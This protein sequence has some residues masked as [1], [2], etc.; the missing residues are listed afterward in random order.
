MFP[1]IESAKSAKEAVSYCL[2]PP[3]GVRG[4]AHTVVRA[5]R[6][7]ID[8]GYLGNYIDELLIM[9]QVESEE[10]V[11][12][13]DEIA[14]VDGV[15]CIQMGPLDLSASLG[16]LWDPGNKKVRETMWEAEKK[17]LESKKDNV[18]VGAYLSGFAM[19]HDGPQYLKSRGYHMVAGAVDVGLFRSAAVED[20][21]SFKMSL[22]EEGSDNEQGEGKDGDEKYWSE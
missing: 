20:V 10:A 1:M 11:K 17:V 12:H 19:P 16:C 8:E 22:I 21:N 15:D 9:C 13:V 2:F 7:G 5:S 14:A 18:D 3:A 4:S 6:Y